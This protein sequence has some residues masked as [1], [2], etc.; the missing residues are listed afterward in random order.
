MDRGWRM[1]IQER[2]VKERG[3]VSN[4]MIV[5]CL[6]KLKGFLATALDSLYIYM[7]CYIYGCGRSVW[8]G[9]IIFICLKPYCYIKAKEKNYSEWVSLR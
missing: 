1:K 4:I 5:G 3:R 2:N 7:V 8:K 6:Y 9:L